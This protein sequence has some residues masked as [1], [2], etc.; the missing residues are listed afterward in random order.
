MKNHGNM[1]SQKENDNFPAT[2]HKDMEYI[3][4][5]DKEFKRA[6]MT[7]FSELQENS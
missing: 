5:T 1:V 2:K 7:K 6:V 4:L 3:D